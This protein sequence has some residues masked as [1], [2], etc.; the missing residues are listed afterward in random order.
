MGI[1]DDFLGW[2]SGDDS[3]SSGAGLIQGNGDS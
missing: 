1:W 2:A 3:E